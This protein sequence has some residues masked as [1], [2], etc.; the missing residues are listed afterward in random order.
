MADGSI[1]PLQPGD[2]SSDLRITSDKMEGASLLLPPDTDTDSDLV[3]E[4]KIGWEWS[5][6]TDKGVRLLPAL[7]GNAKVRHIKLD[8]LGTPEDGV[9]SDSQ[10]R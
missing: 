5:S 9:V 8:E 3:I 1:Q 4:L 7:T 2:A 6:S 10:T